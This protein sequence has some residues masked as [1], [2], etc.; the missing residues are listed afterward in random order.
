MTANKRNWRK[1]FVLV[2]LVSFFYIIFHIVFFVFLAALS[3]DAL[4]GLSICVL[5]CIIYR[6]GGVYINRYLLSISRN[7]WLYF[8]NLIL[9]TYLIEQLF[10][11][12]VDFTKKLMAFQFVSNNFILLE[13]EKVFN[14]LNYMLFN[15][16]I[17][18][19]VLSELF[20][21]RLVILNLYEKNIIS[22]EV[23]LFSYEF[24]DYNLYYFNNTIGWFL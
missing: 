10:K 5:F 21:K 7:V 24:I 23:V 6:F 19:L 18:N 11:K 12:S 4:I 8:V 9:L 3:V 15:K 20:F 13:L 17:L 2:S 22:S 14:E 16:Y 1:S